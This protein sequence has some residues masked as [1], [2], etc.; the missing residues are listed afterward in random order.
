MAIDK[1][2]G[3]LLMTEDG[4]HMFVIYIHRNSHGL[5]DIYYDE[6]ILGC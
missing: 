6:V 4:G 2:L 1:P 5:Y 3:R